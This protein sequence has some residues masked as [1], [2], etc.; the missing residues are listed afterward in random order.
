MMN[1]WG[2][3]LVS[4]YWSTDGSKVCV[5][6]MDRTTQQTCVAVVAQFWRRE[7][8]GG[9]GEEKGKGKGAKRSHC[10]A[11]LQQTPMM[12]IDCSF[13]LMNKSGRGKPAS[14]SSIS[15]SL[16]GADPVRLLTLNALIGWYKQ[17]AVAV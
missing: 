7:G 1:L 16:H 17:R 10:P 15:K 3:S 12:R 2:L 5:G 13:N 4:R 14:I 11:R 9:R 6:M 8:D